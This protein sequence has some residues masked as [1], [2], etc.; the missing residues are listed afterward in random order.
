MKRRDVAPWSGSI[1]WASVALALCGLLPSPSAGQDLEAVKKKVRAQFP[2]VR[3]LSTA[4]L[5]AWLGRTNGLHPMLLDARSPAEYAVSHLPGAR[6]A[7]A[8]APAARLLSGLGTNQAIVVYCSIGYRSSRLVERLQQAGCTNVF[9]L[10]GSIFQ[11]ANE[12]R[13]L[14]RDGQPVKEVHPYGSS[15]GQLLHPEHR[16]TAKPGKE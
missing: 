8:K 16:M 10:D 1:R 15:F 11:W 12:D 3:Q 4:E 6:L 13:L 9:N 5:A 2:S 14:E 7:D